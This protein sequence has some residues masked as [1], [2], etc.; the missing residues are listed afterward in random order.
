MLDH[1]YHS[2]YYSHIWPHTHTH[3]HI[4]TQTHT[5]IHTYTHIHTHTHTPHTKGKLVKIISKKKLHEKKS[6]CLEH[7]IKY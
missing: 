2:K 5:N 7:S 1:D 4:H 6:L 3:T